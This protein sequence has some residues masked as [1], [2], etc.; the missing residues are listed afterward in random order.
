MLHYFGGQWPCQNPRWL[1]PYSAKRS[2]VLTRIIFLREE[3][4]FSG[5]IQEAEIGECDKSCHK[6]VIAG[7]CLTST[8]WDLF[9]T[10]VCIGF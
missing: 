2:L 10:Q 4:F 7:I 3:I 6:T 9:N 1:I 5:S 8:T